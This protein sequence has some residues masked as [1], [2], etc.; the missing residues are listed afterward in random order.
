MI[1]PT[2]REK[3]LDFN[4]DRVLVTGGS[5]GIGRACALAFAARGARVAVNYLDNTTAAEAT[6]AAL[7]GN[8]HCNI[9]ADLANADAVEELVARNVSA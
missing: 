6:M 8:G 1:R 2:V 3:N 7:P 9:R 5:R 4:G